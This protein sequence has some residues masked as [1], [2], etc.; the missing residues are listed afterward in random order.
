MRTQQ[1]RDLA[2]DI[3]G[4]LARAGPG[5][6]HAVVGPQAADLTFEVGPLLQEAPRFVHKAVP[7]VDIGDAGLGRGIPIQRIQEQHVRGRL[8]SP[9]CG[10]SDP[11]HR[12]ALR[13]QD[14]DHLVDLLGVEL[15]PAFLPKLIDAIRGTRALVWRGERR[16]VIVGCIVAGQFGIGRSG[17]RLRGS[18]VCSIRFACGF[19]GGLA[20]RFAA[21][22]FVG[23]V[24]AR[25]T[26]R[27]AIIESEHHDNRI[28][29]L[30]GEDAFRRRGPIGRLSLGLISDQAGDRLVPADHADVRLFGVGVF[31][32]IGEPVRHGVTEHQ[33]VALRYGFAFFGRRRL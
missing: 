24:G 1:P 23:L 4:K 5:E 17:I 33:N 12:H 3:V 11:E 16:R 10:Q 29:L 26:N 19:V 22:L 15:D 21:A 7:D 32:T 20:L 31:K 18:V 25:V 14:S 30:R 13:F 8:G 9:H 6:I 27:C 2:L 28:G